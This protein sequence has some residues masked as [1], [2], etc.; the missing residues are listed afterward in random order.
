[1]IDKKARLTEAVQVIR[2]NCTTY[3]PDHAV[4]DWLEAV[5]DRIPSKA[6]TG[7]DKALAVADGYIDMFGAVKT[8]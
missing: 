7:S 3:G 6:W 5:A 1:V 8:A 4:A 2:A